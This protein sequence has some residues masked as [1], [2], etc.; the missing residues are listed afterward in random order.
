MDDRYD[1]MQ[2]RNEQIYHL[3]QREILTKEKQDLYFE[4]VISELF[5]QEK[6]SQI[7]FSLLD[8]NIL[9]GYGG[10]VHIDWENRN[11]EVSFL[12]KNEDELNLWDIFLKLL[13][14][15]S[16]KELN[17]LKIY[18]YA[19]DLRPQLYSILELNAFIKEA[20][21]VNHI[22]LDEKPINVVLH[23]KFNAEQDIYRRVA[24]FKDAKILFDWVNDN[25]V[26]KQSLNSD[27]VS[28]SEHLVW[29]WSKLYSEKSE[30]YM[31]YHRNEPIGMLR[32]DVDNINKN[33]RI[34][35][36]IAPAE[37]G[38]GFG[39]KMIEDLIKSPQSKGNLLVAE[40]KNENQASNK[41]FEKS[42]FVKDPSSTDHI[43]IW[44][45]WN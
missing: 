28:W 16:F 9:V 32:L 7:L 13:F 5:D 43:N 15:V 22:I 1:I 45:K 14:E 35:Y 23:A 18:T 38:K 25:E 33:K 20:V 39:T 19:F 6:P 36:L 40:V 4:T 29:L 17:M 30:I 12:Q 10:L 42:Y 26:R 37:R 44:K 31:Y 27:P 2:W 8:D 21:L 3:R 24:E 41:I 34:S 11:A